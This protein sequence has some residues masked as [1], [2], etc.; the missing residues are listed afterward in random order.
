[1]DIGYVTKQNKRKTKYNPRLFVI[2]WSWL[3]R[4]KS[5]YLVENK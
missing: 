4:E 2:R 3:A 5:E 1:M